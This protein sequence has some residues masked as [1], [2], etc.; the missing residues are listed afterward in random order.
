MSSVKLHLQQYT[1]GKNGSF[2]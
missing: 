1:S 2:L